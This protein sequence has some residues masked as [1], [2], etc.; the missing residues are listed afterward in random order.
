MTAAGIFERRTMVAPHDQS[1]VYLLASMGAA[2][3]AVRAAAMVCEPLLQVEFTCAS[4]S[5]QDAKGCGVL[6]VHL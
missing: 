4:I 2:C 1:H 5:F 3:I 6:L